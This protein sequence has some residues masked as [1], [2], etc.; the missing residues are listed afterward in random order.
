MVTGG[1]TAGAGSDRTDTTETLAT[2]GSS[3]VTSEAKLPRP[4]RGLRAANIDDRVL[5]FG[6]YTLL[7]CNRYH[8]NIIITGGYDGILVQRSEHDHRCCERSQ[9]HHWLDI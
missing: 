1:I 6:N 8:R 2:D 3:W 7:S 9:S 4:M 5:I